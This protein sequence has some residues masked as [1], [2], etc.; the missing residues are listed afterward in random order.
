[1]SELSLEEQ[2]RQAL[3]YLEKA[4]ATR[5]HGAPSALHDSAALHSAAA[6]GSA[7]NSAPDTA[8]TSDAAPMRHDAL[9]TSVDSAELAPEVKAALA[10]SPYTHLGASSARSASATTHPKPTVSPRATTIFSS[11]SAAASAVSA[12][13][14]SAPV[15][16]AHKAKSSQAEPSS[17]RAAAAEALGLTGSAPKSRAR[18]KSGL[19]VRS[20]E[21]LEA[22]A[23]SY[24][25]LSGEALEAAR[26]HETFQNLLELDALVISDNVYARYCARM[27]A[28][29]LSPYP[30]PALWE[31][32]IAYVFGEQGLISR[33][34]SYY[35]PRPG[36]ITFARH[37]CAAMSSGQI[38]MVE[39]G[40]G[41]GKT[42]SYLVPPLVAGRRVIV[43]TGTKALQDQLTSKDIPNLIKMLGLKHHHHIALKGQSNYV[44]RYLLEGR[45]LSQMM[46]REAQKLIRYVG[47]CADDIDRKRYQATFGEINFPINDAT[48]ALISCDSALCQEMSSNC[49]YAKQKWQFLKNCGASDDEVKGTK[50]GVEATTASVTGLST[51]SSGCPY[52]PDDLPDVTGDHCFIFAARHEA[53]KRQ[54]VAIN[55][56]LFFGALQSN[57]GFNSVNSILP[58]PDVLVFDEAH[59]LPEVGR[60]F[61][62]RHVSLRELVD[63]P[64]VM[65][66]AFKGSSVSVNSGSFQE[67]KFKFSLLVRTLQL[68]LAL[69]DADKRNVLDFKYR[70]QRYPS[71]FELLGSC[72]VHPRER[73]FLGEDSYLA[74]V[75]T[76]LD[77]A[78]SQAFFARLN[79]DPGVKTSAALEALGIKGLSALE[80]EESS[81]EAERFNGA[82]HLSSAELRALE[83]G[84]SERYAQLIAPY[85][86][87]EAKSGYKAY[88][89][90]KEVK[91]CLVPPGDRP[92]E[93]VICDSAGQPVVEPFFRALMAD[94][95]MSLRTLH[96]LFEANREASDKVPALIERSEELVAFIGDFMTTDRNKQGEPQWDNAA[97]IEINGGSE[98]RRTGRKRDYT[99][100]LVV[101]PIDIGKYLGPALRQLR[102]NGTTIV[103]ASATIT[104]NNEFTKFCRDLGLSQSEVMTDIVPSPFDYENH[105]CLLTSA[106]FPQPAESRRIIKCIDMVKEAISCVDGGVFFLTTSYSMMNAAAQELQTLFGTRRK[107]LVQGQAAVP[108]L[109]EEFR[110]DGQAILVGTSSFWEGVDVPGKALSLVIIDKLPFKTIGDPMQV[111]RSE[112]CTHRG[113]NYFKDISIPE[114]I[115]MLRQGVGRLIRNEDDS[116]ALIILDPRLQTNS[117]GQIFF[118][119]LPP[120]QRVTTIGELTSFLNKVKK[121]R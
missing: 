41:T 88:N 114:A 31:F 50:S 21:E 24:A 104:V 39:A 99:Y 18:K 106:H 95:L 22:L 113:G 9:L 62:T 15:R 2:K 80:S 87:Q 109:M 27:K 75:L 55:H 42:Y 101:A 98:D 81:G 8:L 30:R 37:V 107:I 44:C 59:T 103:F 23:P 46:A 74:K 117:Y 35:R 121:S 65:Q 105:A 19:K 85:K 17:L 6:P 20:H 63:L 71:C 45:G 91:P 120:M 92:M 110:Q 28:L 29:G 40:T 64:D 89:R 54:V 56:A 34:L 13:A 14:S 67:A 112:L 93:D 70:H 86:A 118:N 96:G 83:Q 7:A 68:G 53:K 82:S 76:K 60:N 1:M 43:S 11:D 111:A 73:G 78:D 48:R 26:R 100:S 77:N 69:Y 57:N 116:G 119:S 97:W 10:A 108:R 32:N 94:L 36:Q 58:W 90:T 61:F 47:D 66:E 4:R 25:D 115:I 38:L 5:A 84:I 49:P 33:S 16:S 72:L 79:I 51:E 52:N 3:S 102:D 12:E